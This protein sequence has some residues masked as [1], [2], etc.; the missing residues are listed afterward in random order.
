MLFPT[1]HL[2]TIGK[3]EGRLP[4]T[5]LAVDNTLNSLL[6]ANDQLTGRAFL[7]DSGAKISVLP[8]SVADRKNKV[9]HFLQQMEV[10]FP[11]L[12]RDPF[13]FNFVAIRISG[14]SS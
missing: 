10:Q 12:E 3:R 5:A 8:A 13:S 9:Y 4:V 1:M 7:I 11:H 2:H 6:F 14:R